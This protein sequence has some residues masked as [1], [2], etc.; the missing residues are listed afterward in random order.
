MVHFG[1]IDSSDKNYAGDWY[2]HP[3]RQ[4]KEFEDIF[5]HRRGP[6]RLKDAHWVDGNGVHVESHRRLHLTINPGD[7]VISRANGGGPI[8]HLQPLDYLYPKDNIPVYSDVDGFVLSSGG[9]EIFRSEKGGLAF[10]AAEEDGD[11]RINRIYQEQLHR[12]WKL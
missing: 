7:D 10:L 6:L 1:M 4:L 3:D 11:T 5:Q 12:L 9:K 2:H 8:G